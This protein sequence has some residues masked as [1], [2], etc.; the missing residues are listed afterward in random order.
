MNQNYYRY[1][2][3]EVNTSNPLKLVLML[4]DGAINFLKKSIAY[5]GN[6]ESVTKKSLCGY[7]RT[8]LKN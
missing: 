7:I 4:Y 3:I 5:A 1:R 8:L 6:K 2:Q